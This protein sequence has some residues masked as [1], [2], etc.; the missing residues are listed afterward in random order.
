MEFQKNRGRKEITK[1]RKKEIRREEIKENNL[2]NF[3][4]MKDMV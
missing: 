2:G 1:G 4:Y 3:P